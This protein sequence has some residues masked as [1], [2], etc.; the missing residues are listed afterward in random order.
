MG[1]PL[2][3]A[4][5]QQALAGRAADQLQHD[6]DPDRPPA[7]AQRLERGGQTRSAA[8]QGAD[9]HAGRT[10][11]ARVQPRRRPRH[12][13]AARRGLRHRSQN[14]GDRGP[15]GGSPA[16][17]DHRPGRHQLRPDPGRLRDPRQRRRDPLL[18]AGHRHDRRRRRERL[19]RLAGA[20][21]EAHR[22]GN[23]AAQKGRGRAQEA[24]GGRE[25]PA[26]GRGRGESGRRRRGSAQRARTGPGSRRGDA[27]P[28]CPETRD[29]GRGSSE[30]GPAGG[31]TSFAAAETGLR[32]AE[33]G[34]PAPETASRA[35]Q[36][37]P[38]GP[39]TRPPTP[40]TRL[41]N[42]RTGSPR[43]L[44]RPSR[45]RPR[46]P[47]PPVRARKATNRERHGRRREGAPGPH[48]GRDDGLQ[49]RP[50]RGRR[51]HRAGDR[52]AAGQGPGLRRQARRPRHRRGR[53]LLLH[54]RQRQG[55]GDGRGPVRE[56]LRRP[57]RGLQGVRLPGGP[58][59]GRDG[60]ALRLLRRDPGGR[61][62]GRKA[63]L[64]RE[65][66]RR[67]QARQ[68]GRE[69]RH[70]T[71]LEVGERGGAARPVPRQRREARLED[72]RGAAPGARREDR[73][74][75]AQRPIGLFP[76]RRRIGSAPMPDSPEPRFGRILLKLSGEA[77]MGSLDY[78]TDGV[79]VERIAKQVSAIRDRGVEVAIV[80]GAGN[81]Y[82]GLE[83]AA[84]GMDRATGD[85]MGM[86]ATVRNELTLQDAL[87]GLGQ[88]TRV[89]S[90]IDVKEVAEPY[91]RR[92][93]W[94]HLEKG[95]VVIFAAGTGNPFFTT[96]TAAAL[97]ALEI[98]AEAILMAKN[99]VEGVYDADPATNP[100]ATLI[101]TIIPTITRRE[102]IERGLKVM[103]STALSLCMDNDLPIYVFNMGDEQNIDRI[104][105]G[106]KGGHHV[107]NVPY[108]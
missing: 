104:V 90:A 6:V 61:A 84:K 91:I 82:R 108:P 59:R 16:D 89:M 46:I 5:R 4:L 11:Q 8:D 75:R 56:R 48:R 24:R 99:G 42:R 98:H 49:S 7:R 23:G 77:L 45:H 39:Q 93:A 102:E 85:Y 97:R 69:N 107:Y 64:R 43:R 15:R 83:A 12:G 2:P 70:R 65:G 73:R 86:L 34:S 25:S 55:R 81:I 68:R 19:Q 44:R 92:R 60:A 40:R 21:G 100:E 103:D 53:R 96:D 58:A 79:E 101:P 62:R 1:R 27:L 72:D 17:P 22:R 3:N 106:E 28:A 88:H 76:R 66:T 37:G 71:A 74:E 14:R 10:R 80:V 18:R 94:R 41:P 67:R 30:A 105:S 50:D 52:A 47:P 20:G 36:N 13:P 57:Q 63:R 29:S 38:P 35:P 9:E 26:R 51:R 33:T 54:P 78:G 87:E 31:Q 32:G 95:R